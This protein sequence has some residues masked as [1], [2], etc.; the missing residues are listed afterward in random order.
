MDEKNLGCIFGG[1]LLIAVGLFF[2]A[3][4]SYSGLLTFVGYLIVSAGALLSQVGVIAIGV[5]M[6][7]TSV[8]AAA[9]STPRKSASTPGI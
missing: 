4:D 6:G 5:A 2:L 1:L 3:G 8:N 7:M 9:T